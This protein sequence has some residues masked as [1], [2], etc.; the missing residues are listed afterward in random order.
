MSTSC[1][2]EK[3]IKQQYSNTIEPRVNCTVVQS[4]NY[5]IIHLPEE[6]LRFLQEEFKSQGKVD[7]IPLTDAFLTLRIRNSNVVLATVTV[8]QYFQI[9]KPPCP[10]QTF[11]AAG[12][13]LVSDWPV[14]LI[15]NTHSCVKIP[16]PPQ[17]KIQNT[18]VFVETNQSVFSSQT[19]RK[20]F[21][22]SPDPFSIAYTY[23]D[24]IEGSFLLQSAVGTFDPH[25]PSKYYTPYDTSTRFEIKSLSCSIRQWIKLN[26]KIIAQSLEK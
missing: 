3:Y 18:I 17:A 14:S 8:F 6:T 7:G 4:R 5:Y 11:F 25:D 21:F 13:F 1:F 12:T 24:H 22:P 26:K 15:P 20:Q 10:V 19:M 16:L 9:A 2:F 23:N